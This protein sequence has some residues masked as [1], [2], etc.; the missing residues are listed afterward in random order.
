MIV[1]HHKNGTVVK[2]GEDHVV[3]ILPNGTEV[4]AIPNRESPKMAKRLGYGK[5]VNA[6]TRDHDPLHSWLCDRLGMPH[7]FSLMQAAGFDVN[8]RLAGLEEDAVLSVQKF[9]RAWETSQ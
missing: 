5:D 6:M 8:A 1:R 3:T 4:T 7:S 9:K 2:V